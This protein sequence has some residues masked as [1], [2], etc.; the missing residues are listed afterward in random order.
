MAALGVLTSLSILLLV[1]LLLTYLCQK[2]KVS[3]VLILI[4]AGVL[5]SFLKFK[6]QK[7][8]S[9]SNDIDIDYLN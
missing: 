6:G 2:F 4:V 3:N 5:I 1:G 7:L 8:I 9:F